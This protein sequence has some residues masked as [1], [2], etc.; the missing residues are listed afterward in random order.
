[1]EQAKHAQKW[2]HCFNNLVKP[3]RFGVPIEPKTE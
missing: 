2:Q 3:R 1:M